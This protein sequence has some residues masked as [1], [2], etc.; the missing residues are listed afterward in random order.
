ML[1]HLVCI[2]F[3]LLYRKNPRKI[4]AMTLAFFADYV[5]Y[6]FELID[7]QTAASRM[8]MQWDDPTSL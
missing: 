3:R 5:S 7:H 2:E 4:V 6:E 1:K 8:F